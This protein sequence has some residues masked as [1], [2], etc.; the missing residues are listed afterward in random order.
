MTIKRVRDV[1]D[2]D[3]VPCTT[4]I[5]GRIGSGIS[6]NAK[7]VDVMRCANCHGTADRVVRRVKYIELRLT[8]RSERRLK[9]R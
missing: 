2:L 5:R 1:D 3:L 4:C 6:L 7:G 8:T 9:R